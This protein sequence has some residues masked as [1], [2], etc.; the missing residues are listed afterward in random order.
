MDST[1]Q[2]QQ[3]TQLIQRYHW[4]TGLKALANT[5]LCFF[6]HFIV[7]HLPSRKHHRVSGKITGSWLW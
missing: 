1:V 2:H 4:L 5:Q 7:C 3:Y 6:L